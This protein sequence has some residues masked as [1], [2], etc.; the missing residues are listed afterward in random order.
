MLV[1]LLHFSLIIIVFLVVGIISL[2]AAVN[3]PT[4]S[5][6]YNFDE[7]GEDV[8]DH[9]LNGNDGKI[10]GDINREEGVYGNAIVLENQSW[11]DMNGAEFEGGPVDGFTIA[12]WINHS[13]S[14]DPQTLLDAIGTDHGNGLFHM[15]IRTGGFRFFHRDGSNTTVFNLNPGPVI[16][17]NKWVH[18]AGTY[19]SDSG[20][21]RTYIN[22]EETHTGTGSGKCSDNW[23][24]TAGI[25]HHKEGRWFDGRLDEYYIF[26]RALPQEEIS[27]VMNGALLAV[28]PED[29]LTTTWG[30]IK[31]YR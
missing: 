20:D 23:G 5:V 18:F 26:G 13:G 22:G 14:S 8:T 19:D 30:D 4:L 21:I 16:E 2:E 10:V 28:E 7:E 3:D 27:E 17:G 1:R 6:Y 9:S 11:I 12:V 15:E 29:K 25:G 31:S 24:V